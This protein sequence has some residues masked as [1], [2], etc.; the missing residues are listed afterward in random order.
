VERSKRGGSGRKRLSVVYLS[1]GSNQGDRK[2]NIE[3]A[4]RLVSCLDGVKVKA[5]SSLHRT[6][7][8]GD[9]LQPYFLNAVIKIETAIQPETL[10]ESL[11]DIEKRLGRVRTTRWGPRT[12]DIDILTYD[13]LIYDSDTLTIPH[14][15]FHERR[16]VLEL[17][18]EIDSQLRHPVLDATVAELLQSCEEI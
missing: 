11:L 16:F 18:C 1:L 4:V 3:D 13:D 10:L 14:P 9:P 5:Q 8:L 12:I 17:I 15:L 6:V 2:K 7:A